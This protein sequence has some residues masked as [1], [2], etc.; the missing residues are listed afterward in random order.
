MNRKF[1]LLWLDDDF[2][3]RP[4][5]FEPI[6]KYIQTYNATLNLIQV[7]KVD[8]FALILKQRHSQTFAEI[9][10]IDLI[11]LD[12]MIKPLILDPTFESLGF[13]VKQ[14][15]LDVGCQILAIMNNK[16]FEEYRPN[17]LKPYIGRPITLITNKTD[18]AFEWTDHVEQN[19]INDV[20]NFKT[21]VKNNTYQNNSITAYNSITNH[22]NESIENFNL[23]S[24][25]TK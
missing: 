20:K 22:L 11:W 10:Y 7:S 3:I 14:K 5:I 16:T 21:L 23:I 12:V 24:N 17:W 9:D 13:N 15:T 8:E 25:S 2:Y 19:V 1:N 18:I 4:K 6:L